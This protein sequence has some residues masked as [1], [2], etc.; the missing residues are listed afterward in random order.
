MHGHLNVKFI[1]HG[2]NFVRFRF[3]ARIFGILDVRHGLIQVRPD[4]L[5]L[6]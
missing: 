3:S 6:R 5:C 2:Y 4:C 1:I